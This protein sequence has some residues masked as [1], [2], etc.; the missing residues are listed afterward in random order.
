MRNI[1]LSV[2]VV[3]TCSRFGWAI[4]G[5]SLTRADVSVAVRACEEANFAHGAGIV[6]AMRG[7]HPAEIERII[8]DAL[9][10]WK[11]TPANSALYAARAFCI[12]ELV[13]NRLPAAGPD[14]AA[15][16]QP[17][18]EDL[19]AE[20]QPTPDVNRFQELGLE[21]FYYGPDGEWT[22]RKDPIDLNELALKHLDSRWGRQAFL[23]MT[24]LGWSQGAC[25]EG[26]DQFR[27]VIKHGEKFLKKYPGSEVSNRVRLE[28]ANAYATWWNASQAEPDAYSNPANYKAG[29]PEAKRRAIELYR[30]YIKV[31]KTPRAD[32][33]KRLKALQENP[34]GSDEFDYFCE[35]YED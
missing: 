19:V 7:G 18:R 12:H 6:H 2:V 34:K 28:L 1:W 22:L 9:K 15:E 24:L 30:E 21:Y 10:E 13:P 4:Y 25:Q 32:V 3:V 27:A 33:R 20:R 29:A 8:G 35:D 26:P 5:P 23:M 31:Q 17:T 14:P 11:G 16:R